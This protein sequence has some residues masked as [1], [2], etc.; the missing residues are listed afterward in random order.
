[1]AAGTSVRYLAKA[2]AASL[3]FEGAALRPV[4]AL[5]GPGPGEE[6]GPE[7]HPEEGGDRDADQEPAAVR[8]E[9]SLRGHDVTS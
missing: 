7:P 3:L 8:D 1:M 2:K 9:L 6:Q 4:A 5:G